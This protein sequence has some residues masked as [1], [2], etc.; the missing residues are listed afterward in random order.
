[1]WEHHHEILRL[2]IMGHSRDEI[3]EKVGCTPQT[4]TNTL[5]SRLGQE[6][7]AL[8]RAERDTSCTDVASAIR[9]LAPRALEIMS[10]VMENGTTPAGVRLAA[11]KDLLDRAGF[12]A[13]KQVQVTSVTAHLTHDEIKELKDRAMATATAQAIVVNP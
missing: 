9:E 10:E 13:P 2:A 11:S 4:V 12:A 3:S 8:L 6:K 7:L 5:N 1:M